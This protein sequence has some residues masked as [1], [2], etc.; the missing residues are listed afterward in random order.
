MSLIANGGKILGGVKKLWH[1][2]RAADIKYREYP[3][4]IAAGA[5]L[6]TGLYSY[7][8]FKENRLR[9]KD[10]AALASGHQ[11]SAAYEFSQH[12]MA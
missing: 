2:S 7:E 5:I 8:K 6:G 9:K 4:T 1:T 3:S 12:P 11:K 10:Q